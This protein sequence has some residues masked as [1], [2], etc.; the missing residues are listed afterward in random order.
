MFTLTLFAGVDYIR[1]LTLGE[2]DVPTNFI[3]RSA[4]SDDFSS[5]IYIP[6]GLP[7]GESIQRTAYVCTITKDISTV[8]LRLDAGL[9]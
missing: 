5:P 6:F 4:R 9:E 1:F 2:N 7:F 8:L 3:V